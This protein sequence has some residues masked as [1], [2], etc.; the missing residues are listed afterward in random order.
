MKKFYK[1]LLIIIWL[2]IIFFFSNQNGDSSASLTNGFIEKFLWFV[3]NDLVFMLIR[4]LA[5]FCEY[6]ILGILVYN[7][8]REFTLDKMVLV[9]ILLC[10]IFASTDEF[11]QLFVGGRNSQIFDV[12]LDSL[13]SCCG[14]LCINLWY[15]KNSVAKRQ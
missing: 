7:F 1:L 11:H 8:L 13:G 3:D 14:I 4:K 9:A 10:F 12:I 2:G 5:H 6:F 15:K